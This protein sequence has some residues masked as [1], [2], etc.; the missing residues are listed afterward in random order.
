MPN[1]DMLECEMDIQILQKSLSILD[2][3][4][5][6]S[7]NSVYSGNS[8]NTNQFSYFLQNDPIKL[9]VEEHGG[10]QKLLNLVFNA[11]GD[12]NKYMIE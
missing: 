6:C 4:L 12:E 3:I 8:S 9:A 11:K 2:M 1:L 5:R 10:K 7:L